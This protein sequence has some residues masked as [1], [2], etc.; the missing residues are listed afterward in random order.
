[1]ARE[2]STPNDSGQNTR[3]AFN[4]EPDREL[5][6]YLRRYFATADAIEIV[7]PEKIISERERIVATKQKRYVTDKGSLAKLI[8]G[9][10]SRCEDQDGNEICWRIRLE[11]YIYRSFDFDERW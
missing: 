7:D 9:T 11:E 3:V 1:M 8:K 6:G 5:S 4:E 10:A 2:S